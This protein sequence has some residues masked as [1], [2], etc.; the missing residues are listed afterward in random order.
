MTEL[1]TNDKYVFPY[2]AYNAGNYTVLCVNV[3]FIPFFRIF[4]AEMQER[5][6]WSSREDWWRSYQVFAEMEETIMSGCLGELVEGQNRLYRLLDSALNGTAYTA[7]IDPDTNITTVTPPQ[8]VVP[9]NIVGIAPGLRRQLLDMQGIINAGWFNI[10]GQPATIADVVRS[11]RVG[12]D[13]QRQNIIQTLNDILS[14]GADAAS[15]FAFVEDL[16]ADTVNTL[17]EGA[18]VA[19][20]IASSMANAAMLGSMA[21]QI[22]RLIASLDGGGIT[23][24][25]DNVLM[26]LRGTDPATAERN[27]VDTLGNLLQSNYDAYN[28]TAVLPDMRDILG[29]V[30][31]NT[32]TTASNTGDIRGDIQALNNDNNFRLD[33][34]ISDNDLIEALLTEIRDYV[35]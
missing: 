12:S 32:F 26:A 20:L 8:P 1:D 19:T 7:T 14:A 21:G 25:D 9:P 17:G 35:Q 24:P 28:N 33:T 34:I 30:R 22:D 5:W 13:T 15:I 4:F 11:L 27:V 2:D 31:D 3:A 10:G 6:R 16:F 29:N 23:G 18:V